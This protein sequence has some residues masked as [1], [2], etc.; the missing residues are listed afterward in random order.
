MKLKNRLKKVEQI[1]IVIFFKVKPCCKLFIVFPVDRF[2]T[3]DGNSI[4]PWP[5]R[6]GYTLGADLVMWLEFVSTLKTYII[7]RMLTI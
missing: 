4:T 1:Q 6:V 3:F 7:K 5:Y 2:H